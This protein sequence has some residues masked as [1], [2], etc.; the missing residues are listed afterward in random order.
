MD[1]K[2]DGDD[3]DGGAGH[4]CYKPASGSPECTAEASAGGVLVLVLF[5]LVAA[6]VSLW[7]GYKC[8]CTREGWWSCCRRDG[9]MSRSDAQ[10]RGRKLFSPREG[11]VLQL[12]VFVAAVFG[13][14]MLLASTT[15][16]TA[17]TGS[18]DSSPKRSEGH[19]IPDTVLVGL[20]H[21][22]INGERLELAAARDRH[23]D[24][25]GFWSRMAAVGPISGVALLV[26]GILLLGLLA[27]TCKRTCSSRRLRSMETG[28]KGGNWAKTSCGLFATAVVFSAL[29]S[30]LL[31]TVVSPQS[32]QAT[33]SAQV[34]LGAAFAAAA[35]FPVALVLTFSLIRVLTTASDYAPIRSSDRSDG[36]SYSG[37]MSDDA[38]TTL[39]AST[40]DLDDVYE[41]E[42]E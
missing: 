23:P 33:V 5:C 20:W 25:A 35:G 32:R 10:R 6:A 42:Y 30:I 13:L 18:D 11:L 17:N 22:D 39:G 9:C 36:E 4:G 34:S 37:C 24:Y 38:T 3:D 12:L 29:P 27:L 41:Y 8:C 1:D 31:G 2:M 7:I 19:P 40:V 21:A 28:R 15:W 14:I 26:T 16:L